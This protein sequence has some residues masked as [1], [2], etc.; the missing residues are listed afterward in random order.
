MG[1]SVSMQSLRSR[2]RVGNRL[3]HTASASC[4]FCLRSISGGLVA[5]QDPQCSIEADERKEL[6]MQL[7][8]RRSSYALGLEWSEGMQ[9]G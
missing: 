9:C 5:L 1:R 6:L 4:M 7:K 8:Q 2:R 3:V